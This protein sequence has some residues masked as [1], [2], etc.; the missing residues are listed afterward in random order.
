MGLSHDDPNNIPAMLA[1]RRDWNFGTTPQ[2][3]KSLIRNPLPFDKSCNYDNNEMKCLNTSF[4]AV[5]FSQYFQDYYLYTEHF[6]YLKRTGIYA[7]IAT[8]EP[9]KISNTYFFDRCLGWSGICVEA[10]DNYY[11]PIYRERSCRLVP[12]C[13]GSVEGQEVT[14]GMFGGLGG[15]LG[16]TYKSLKR[17][18]EQNHTYTKKLTCTTMKNVLDVHN[19]KTIDYLSLDVEGHELEVLRGFQLEDV[20]INIMTI[21]SSKKS[22]KNIDSFLRS[23][24][25][26]PH[27]V[28]NESDSKIISKQRNFLREDSIYVH[29]S[30]TFGSPV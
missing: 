5:M 1:R 15:I 29:E 11:A 24:G 18:N 7:D 26:L 4:D 13:V 19:V 23:F 25:Y 10:N 28:D 21:E 22:S 2:Y 12:T 20:K 9:I 30:V 8:N 6:K 16:K 27:H 14:F 3:C 17:F